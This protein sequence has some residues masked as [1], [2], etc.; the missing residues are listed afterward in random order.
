L[1][2]KIVVQLYHQLPTV[3]NWFERASHH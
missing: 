2:F 1:Q 3:E